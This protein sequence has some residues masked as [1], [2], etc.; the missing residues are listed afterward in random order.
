MVFI[1]FYSRY[2]R[3]SFPTVTVIVKWVNRN[4]KYCKK[5]KWPSFFKDSGYS[6]SSAEM[7]IDWVPVHRWV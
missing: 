3:R 6:Y 7:D 5:R 2:V 4:R 1:L